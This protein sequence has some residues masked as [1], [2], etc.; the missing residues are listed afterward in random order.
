MGIFKTISKYGLALPVGIGNI[1]TKGLS[2]VTGKKYGST[3]ISEAAE[4]KFGK[5]LGLAIVGTAAAAGVAYGGVAGTITAAKSMIPT[6]IGKKILAIGVTAAAVSSPTI[7]TALLEA[8]FTAARTGEKVA[9][10]VEN[11]PPEI[12]SGVSSYGVPII[13]AAG[14][15]YAVEQAA[16]AAGV[17]GGAGFIGIDP[18][19]ELKK[20]VKALQQL[21]AISGEDV[22]T[23]GALNPMP[24]TIEP[25]GVVPKKRARKTR[26]EA[27]QQKISQ[28]VNVVVSQNNKN[29]SAHR[30]TNKYL[31]AIAQ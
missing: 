18:T 21:P 14:V 12:K 6:T 31:N 13:A 23:T 29:Y 27:L 24:S 9:K 8:P 20:D 28:K 10:A 3:S 4:T 11:L 25:Q 7:A 2:V 26:K 19:K 5:T 22:T 30:I 16:E 15:G 1:A 17:R